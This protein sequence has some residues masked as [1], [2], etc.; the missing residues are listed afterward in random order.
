ML[1]GA[2]A[3]R[4]GNALWDAGGLGACAEGSNE[5]WWK[6]PGVETADPE[7]VG[8]PAAKPRPESD[9]IRHVQGWSQQGPRPGLHLERGDGVWLAEKPNL[10]CSS[11]WRPHLCETTR[12]FRVVRD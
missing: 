3:K 8:L 9:V 4:Q 7:E 12:M 1:P 11:D 2:R 10:H 5:V 6:V